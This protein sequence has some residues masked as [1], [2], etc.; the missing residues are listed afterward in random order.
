VDELRA[1]PGV[2]R[3][4]EGVLELRFA[5]LILNEATREVW[6]GEARVEL[7]PTE[8]S[9]LRYFLMNPHRVLTKQQILDR[10]WAADFGGDTNIV[11]TYVSY[12]RRKLDPFGP[13]LI[14]TVRLVGYALRET[15]A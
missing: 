13:P 10:V 2:G 4:E 14:H 5:D 11:E 3:E 1:T 15:D 7:T 8:F 6:R 9:L 12:L